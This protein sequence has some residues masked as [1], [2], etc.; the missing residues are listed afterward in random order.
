ML[1]YFSSHWLGV[2]QKSDREKIDKP[3]IVSVT[4]FCN[5]MAISP[6]DQARHLK[7]SGIFPRFTE[8]L[9]IVPSDR[10]F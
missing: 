6:T 5:T 4:H 3:C 1:C 9:P 10:H 8:A 7:D 2:W